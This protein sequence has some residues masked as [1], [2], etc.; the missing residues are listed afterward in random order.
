M[1]KPVFSVMTIIPTNKGFVWWSIEMDPGTHLD[2]IYELLKA[3]GVVRCTRL[4]TVREDQDDRFRVIRGRE[5]MIL[6]K[7]LVGTITPSHVELVDG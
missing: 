6:G 5:P 3:D 2:H 4:N 1:A 7:G